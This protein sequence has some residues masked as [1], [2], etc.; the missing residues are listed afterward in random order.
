MKICVL[1]PDYSTSA[2]DYQLYDPP[3]NLAKILPNH[4]VDTVFLHKLTTYKQLKN[5]SGKGY[6]IFVNLCE[7]Y[8]EWD[9]PGI[10]VIYFLELLNLPFTGPSA[11]LYDPS[12]E[13]MKLVAFYQNVS[14]PAY[15]IVKANE[16]YQSNKTNL[17]FPL[18]IKP[19]KA[20][21]SLGIDEHSLVCTD[22]ALQ[23]QLTI[24]QNEYDT[25][26]IEEYINGREFTVL[27]A[28][29]ADGKS[30]RAFQPIEYIFPKNQPYKTYALK[31]SELH[32][33][34]NISLQDQQLSDE[35]KK[36]A[37][38]IFEGFGGVGY[39]RL[40]FRMNE[41]G[42]LFFL[43]INFTCSVF[44]ENGFE[45]SADFIL[46]YDGIGKQGFLEHIIQE[47]IARHS[48]Q[49]KK[50]RLQNNA[51]S[52]FGIY[53]NSA[54]AKG[55]IIF[56]GE[57]MAQRIVTKKYVEENWSDAEKLTF[58][59]YAYPLGKEVYLLWGNQPQDWAPQNHSCAPNTEFIGLN[60][61]ATRAIQQDEELTLDYAKFLDNE[62]EPFQ[63]LC[64][65]NNC[66]GRIIGDSLKR[67]E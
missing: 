5:L 58:R 3:R 2:I 35:I 7:A 10:D 56:K 32:N 22:E 64:G 50:Y 51:I 38:G 55:E 53:A 45:G 36:A 4:Q 6:Q 60:V 54:I 43:E 41:D 12:K 9:V 26:L 61:H 65:S 40:D 18:F 33:D 17:K 20:G 13:I 30:T 23:K 48:R 37:I 57:E 16:T 46:A 52:G 31:T 27:V 24:I 28:A 66:R 29:N 59:K 34:A 42:K 49:Q 67:F 62:T 1:L 21:D 63:C 25:I 39:A 44:Y 15:I 8:L 14:T 11:A 19:A 47:G